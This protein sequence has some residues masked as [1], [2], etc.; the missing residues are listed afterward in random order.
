MNIIK[1][2]GAIWYYLEGTIQ[3][4]PLYDFPCNTILPFTLVYWSNVALLF[5]IWSNLHPEE[6][7]LFIPTLQRGC[8]KSRRYYSKILQ[9]LRNT[10]SR[11]HAKR[12]NRIL[13]DLITL[14]NHVNNI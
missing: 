12:I 5:N 14:E 11:G 1:S 2:D 7:A 9:H 13:T 10:N 4:Y 3:F 6:D 8:Y